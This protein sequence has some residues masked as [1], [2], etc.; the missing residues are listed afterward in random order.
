MTTL[1][2]KVNRLDWNVPIVTPSGTPTDEFQRKWLQQTATNASIPNLTTAANVSS[3]LDLVASTPGSLLVR[4]ATTWGGLAP[5]TAG[6]VLTDSGVGIPATWQLPHYIP[7]GG[8]TGQVL[9][10]NSAT[11]YDVSWQTIATSSGAPGSAMDDGTNFYLAMLDSAGQLVLDAFG[12]PIFGIE[13]LPLTAIP[14]KLPTTQLLISGTTY[15]PASAAVKWI[16][17]RMVGGGAG[18]AGG[19]ALTGDAVNGSPGT[20]TVFNGVHAAGGSGGGK[21]GGGGSGGTGGTGTANL[22]A[23]GNTGGF[24]V[25][26]QAGSLNASATSNGSTPGGSPLGGSSGAG[27]N[28]TANTGC[29]G[30][31]GYVIDAGAGV[32]SGINGGSGGTGEYVELV[33]PYAASYAYSIGAGGAG[34]AAGANGHTGFTGGSGVIYV[35]EFYL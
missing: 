13:V 27:S 17:V 15:T 20:D 7:A 11:N 8:T 9:E 26:Q 4:R 25:L 32:T 19:G 23:Q 12:D 21:F 6:F 35:E 31:G 3:V 28:A 5:N 29:G 16:R 24:G 34:G 18:G 33:L 14:F 1:T 22:R 10:K 30:S 2:N